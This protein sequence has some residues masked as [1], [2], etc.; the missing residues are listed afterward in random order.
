MTS[1]LCCSN[2]P[3]SLG[4]SVQPWW[5][6]GHPFHSMNCLFA[7]VLLIL[8][9]ASVL[10]SPPRPFPISASQTIIVARNPESPLLVVPKPR[11]DC[12]KTRWLIM[13]A[14]PR[15][16]Q[17]T[18]SIRLS[19]CSRFVAML[20]ARENTTSGIPGLPETAN[21]A[22]RPKIGNFGEYGVQR[23]AVPRPIQAQ[24]CGALF[25]FALRK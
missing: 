1:W 14:K 23:M 18:V 21:R 10:L 13:L 16:G 6:H 2:L 17:E 3:S 9:V 7:W 19:G 5:R 22:R 25:S 15:G 11:I 4:I 20:D 12:V 24:C 8:G